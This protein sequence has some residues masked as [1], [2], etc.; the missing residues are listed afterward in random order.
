MA[1]ER[2][3][4][5]FS[6]PEVPGTALVMALIDE[7][8]TE[9]LEWEPE[10]L[11]MEIEATW[12]AKPPREACDKINALATVLTTNQFF[13]SLDAFVAVCTALYGRGADPQHSDFPSI[14]EMCWAVTETHLLDEAPDKFAQDIADYARERLKLEGWN[15]AP[16]MLQRITGP[17]QDAQDMTINDAMTDQG[18]DIQAYWKTQAEKERELN[19]D[20]M[21]RLEQTARILADLPLR[22]GNREVLLRLRESV[23]RAQAGQSQGSSRA[24]EPSALPGIL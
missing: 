10:T 24:L 13:A 9:C 5:L 23:E 8:G 7:F 22:Y 12:R 4:S 18:G 16:A 15:K 20:I 21:A 3:R 19:Q 1:D 17:W 14:H 6:D 11:W 2:L